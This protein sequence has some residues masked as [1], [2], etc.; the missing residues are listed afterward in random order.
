MAQAIIVC[1]E[2]HES[3]IEF[4]PGSKIDEL[5]PICGAKTRRVFKEADI[6]SVLPDNVS[7][8]GQLLTWGGLPSGKDRS[9][10]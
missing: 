10:F 4:K 6:G 2:G 3:K 1:T 8:A 7:A 9:T 5:C